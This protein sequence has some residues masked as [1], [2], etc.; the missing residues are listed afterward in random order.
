MP[1]SGRSMTAATEAGSPRSPCTTL[2]PGASGYRSFR[3]YRI[4]QHDF[5]DCLAGAVG[6]GE[7]SARPERPGEATA[8]EAGAAP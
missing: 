8:D 5:V 6:P 2:A 7:L 3:H 1:M 4:E